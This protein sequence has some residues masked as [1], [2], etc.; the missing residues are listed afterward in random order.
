MKFEYQ[1]IEICNGGEIINNTLLVESMR[2]FQQL[3]N[4]FNE[5]CNLY[6]LFERQSWWLLE[7]KEPI[8]NSSN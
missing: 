6:G 5:T 3:L 4:N 7:T 1:R 2:N 8:M